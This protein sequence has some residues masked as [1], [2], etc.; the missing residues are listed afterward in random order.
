MIDARN[1]SELE[2]TAYIIKLL[3]AN[4]PDAIFSVGLTH[5]E[6]ARAIP[7]EMIKQTVQLPSY[8][9][10]QICNIEDENSIKELIFSMRDIPKSED[11]D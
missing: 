9:K 1:K 6:K 5:S 7:L 3:F 4:Y 8:A 11:D 10:L 2:Y